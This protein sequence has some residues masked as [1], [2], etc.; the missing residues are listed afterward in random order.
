VIKRPIPSIFDAIGLL[1]MRVSSAQGEREAAHRRHGR[2]AA[3]P[4]RAIGNLPTLSLRPPIRAGVT[5]DHGARPGHA[6]GVTS[7][8]ADSSQYIVLRAE[9]GLPET[10][11]PARYLDRLLARA[12]MVADGQ[13]FIRFHEGEIVW[14][15]PTDEIDEVD[16]GAAQVWI[17][18][19]TLPHDWDPSLPRDEP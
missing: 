14:A 3:T 16:G 10:D 18:T 6:H 7:T 8:D 5:V 4:S 2:P 1:I 11:R 15:Y 9:P 13:R 12:E 17:V 19:R